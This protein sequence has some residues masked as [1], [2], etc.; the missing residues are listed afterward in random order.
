LESCS[1]SRYSGVV[2]NGEKKDAARVRGQRELARRGSDRRQK[3]GRDSAAPASLGSGDSI[4]TADTT[5]PPSFPF[6]RNTRPHFSQASSVPATDRM[7]LGI[8][9]GSARNARTSAANPDDDDDGNSAVWW[10]ADCG[11][12]QASMLS[13]P[14]TDRRASISPR[15]AP[16]SSRCPP[17]ARRNQSIEA[18]IKSNSDRR[19]SA[20]AHTKANLSVSPEDNSRRIPKRSRSPCSADDNQ[21][22]LG[23]SSVHES[24]SLHGSHCNASYR[25]AIVQD[26]P[27]EQ[28]GETGVMPAP[29]PA[30]P[31]DVEDEDEY[32]DATPTPPS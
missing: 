9:S 29:A 24:P 5:P 18:P 12:S 23:K 22:K 30:A 8:G 15:E 7:D 28:F 20:A 13:V 1:E 4:V 19:Q 32:V 31:S 3:A 6:E 16:P 21:L 14:A 25:T 27:L 2:T 10:G 17:T 26:G 11:G